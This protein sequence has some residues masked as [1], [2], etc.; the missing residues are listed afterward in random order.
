MDPDVG[1][2]ALIALREQCTDAE[3]VVDEE[4]YRAAVE[5]LLAANEAP[6]QPE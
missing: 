3:G 5:E 2:Q 4:R 1:I 6:A